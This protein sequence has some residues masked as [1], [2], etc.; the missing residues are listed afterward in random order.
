M[1]FLLLVD[2][3]WGERWEWVSDARDFWNVNAA[4]RGVSVFLEEV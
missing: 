3:V 1:V 4:R 2:P